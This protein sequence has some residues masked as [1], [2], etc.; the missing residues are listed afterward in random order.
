[1]TVI[2]VAGPVSLGVMKW[3]MKLNAENHLVIDQV[4]RNYVKLR[5]PLGRVMTCVELTY[6]LHEIASLD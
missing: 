5:A 4:P 3:A 1:M 2:V 6:D